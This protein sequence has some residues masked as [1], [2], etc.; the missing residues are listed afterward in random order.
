MAALLAAHPTFKLPEY[1]SA[2]YRYTSAVRITQYLT[3]AASAPAPA[4]LV[5]AVAAAA[6]ALSAR[7]GSF[8]EILVLS[9]SCREIANSPALRHYDAVSAADPGTLTAPRPPPPHPLPCGP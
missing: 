1:P 9:T 4:T 5:L 7:A 2:R 6:A 8:R 3:E